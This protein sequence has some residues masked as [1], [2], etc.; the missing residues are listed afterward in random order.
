MSDV[1]DINVMLGSYVEDEYNGNSASREIYPTF[2]SNVP[3]RVIN[4]N[5]EEFS[6]IVN[7]NSIGNSERT[8]EITKISSEE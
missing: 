5:D 1:E 4:L 3:Q 8:Q 7:S 2:T 6:A